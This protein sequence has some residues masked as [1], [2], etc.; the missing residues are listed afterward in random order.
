LF[1]EVED[2]FLELIAVFPNEIGHIF[3]D[4]V[5]HN[6]IE[7]DCPFNTKLWAMKL[8]ENPR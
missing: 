8:S 1:N 5:L 4:Y 2:A 6:Y 3:S 7:P